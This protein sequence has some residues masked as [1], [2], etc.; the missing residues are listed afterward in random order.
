MSEKSAFI[1]RASGAGLVGAVITVVSGVLVQAV[2][3]PTSNVSDEMWSYPWS[4]DALVVVSL[5]YTVAHIL[6]GILLLGV[7]R[8][9]AAGSSRAAATGLGLSVAGTAL[10]LVGELVSIPIRD[11][12]LDD[13]S[14]GIVGATFGLGTVLS[15]VGFLLAGKG[16]LSAGH[17]D[18]WRRYSLFAT[19]LWCVALTGIAATSALPIGVAVYGAGLAAV[20]V[21]LRSPPAVARHGKAATASTRVGT[22]PA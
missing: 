19:G 12:A 14:A 18:G 5:V 7:W 3:Q 11:A 4:S 8:S 6:I 17:W 20:A 1:R 9:G 10:L 21:A 2:V 15:A 16:V 13:T 22:Q